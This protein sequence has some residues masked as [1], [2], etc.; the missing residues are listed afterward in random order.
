MLTRYRKNTCSTEGSMQLRPCW[1]FQVLLVSVH[2]CGAVAAPTPPLSRDKGTQRQ[3]CKNV[4]WCQRIARTTQSHLT[5]SVSASIFSLFF[6]NPPT[7]LLPRLLPLFSQQQN[8]FFGSLTTYTW[9]CERGQTEEAHKE[10]KIM[11][12]KQHKTVKKI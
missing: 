12:E 8:I 9:C 3:T 6:T 7:L 2:I 10:S 4:G 1:Y 11:S 5:S